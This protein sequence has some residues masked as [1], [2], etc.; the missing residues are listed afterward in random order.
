MTQLNYLLFDFTDEED[1]ACSFDALASVL[2][3][4]LAPLVGEV[5]AVLGWASR[6]FGAPPAAGGEGEWDFALHALGDAD[7][8]LE[9][10]Y[11]AQQGRVVMPSTPAGRV[12][13]ALTVT[14]TAA[15]GEA[16]RHAFPDAA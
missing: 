3:P 2:P 8:P 4:R 12:T 10:A 15:F 7:V 14:G 1:G 16:F 13:L 5:E 11:D 9:I 6:E